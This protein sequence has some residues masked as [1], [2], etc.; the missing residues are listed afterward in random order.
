MQR[1]IARERLGDRGEPGGLRQIDQRR[2]LVERRNR[3]RVVA[4]AE[5]QRQAIAQ[6]PLVL[7]VARDA[8]FVD[9]ARRVGGS[10][11]RAEK[12]RRLVLQERRQARER[13]RPVAE[14]RKVHERRLAL[15]LGAQCERVSAAA[16]DEIVADDEARLALRERQHLVAADAGHAG[17]G[18]DRA[19]L[20]PGKEHQQPVVEIRARRFL[21][22]AR[23]PK[24]TV[25]ASSA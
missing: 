1:G 19:A 4:K 6:P 15:V 14:Q 9:I 3:A 16:P 11:Q 10:R 25:L 2:R 22:G 20:A 17:A 5:V 8:P 18:V 13:P 7:R 23:G 12:E 24:R 21:L